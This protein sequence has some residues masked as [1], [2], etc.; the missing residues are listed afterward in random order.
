MNDSTRLSHERDQAILFLPD[1]ACREDLVNIDRAN[2]YIRLHASQWYEIANS[3]RGRMAA[4]GSLLFVT[5]CDKAKSWRLGS[6]SAP[7]NTVLSG[8]AGDI[9]Y[10]IQLESSDSVQMR[11]GPTPS[12]DT[13]NQC[14]FLRSLTVSTQ[15]LAKIVGVASSTACKG[16]EK[17]RERLDSLPGPISTGEEYEG[18]HVYCVND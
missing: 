12:S 2:T 4:D 15:E 16:N 18:T 14:I 10:S 17:E 8:K 7:S 1:G 13:E 11:S 9:S 3:R 5:G 6:I